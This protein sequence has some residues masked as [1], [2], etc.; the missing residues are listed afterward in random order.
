ML[1]LGKQ[2]EIEAYMP[3]PLSSNQAA[4]IASTLT[5]MGGNMVRVNM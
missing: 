2:K 1:T 3:L 4:I 5:L